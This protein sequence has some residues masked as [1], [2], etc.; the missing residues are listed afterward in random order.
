MTGCPAP[1]GI[2]CERVE[3]LTWVSIFQR[4]LAESPAG[5]PFLAR[6]LR[7]KWD[8]LDPLDPA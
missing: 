3:I 4:P 2:L 7:E 1:S 5:A 6:H 8:L